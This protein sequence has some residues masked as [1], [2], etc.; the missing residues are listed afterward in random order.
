MPVKV[1][2]VAGNANTGAWLQLDAN[3]KGEVEVAFYNES[4][5]FEMVTNAADATEAAAEKTAS[6]TYKVPAGGITCPMRFRVDP[7]RTWVRS[8]TASATS[9]SAHFQW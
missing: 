7:C 3:I 2:T 4:Q 6:R 5:A 9:F 8:T 1:N